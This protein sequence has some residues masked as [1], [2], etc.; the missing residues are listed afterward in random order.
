ME[1]K[2][3]YKEESEKDPG[4]NISCF[5]IKLHKANDAS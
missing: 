1:R 2:R 3:D 5:L 4:Y